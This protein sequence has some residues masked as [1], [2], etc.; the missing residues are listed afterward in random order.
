MIPPG[1]YPD[2]ARLA[3]KL[4]NLGFRPLG[5]FSPDFRPERKSYAAAASGGYLIKGPDAKPWVHPQFNISM[6]DD[7]N[8]EAV[9]WWRD[10][11]LHRAIVDLGFDGGMY[12]VGEAVPVDALFTG[13]QTGASLHNA[14]PTLYAK[15]ATQALQYLKPD[16]LFFFRSGYTGAQAYQPGTWSGDPFNTWEPVSGLASIV[17]AALGAGLAGFAYFHTEVGGFVD[18]GLRGTSERELY[19]RWMQLAAFAAMFRDEYGD[20]RGTPT[21]IWTDDQTLAAFRRYARIHQALRPYLLQAAQ[22]AQTTGMPLLRHLALAYPQDQR[23][24]SESGSYLLGD[25]MVVSPVTQP[26]ADT[27]LAYLPA[28]EWHHWWDSAVF[29]GPT[30]A[31]VPAPLDQIPIFVRTD[32]EPPLPDPS[33]FE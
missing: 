21:Y 3:S 32:V 5:Y 30:E 9:A 1:T 26:G 24:W 29:E 7:A 20:R 28:G 31:L 13:G 17:P 15:A 6:L 8:P 27:K 16:G 14:F 11:P 19:F 4:R 33:V 25:H 12:D 23:S 10:G 2:P 22:Q 18:A